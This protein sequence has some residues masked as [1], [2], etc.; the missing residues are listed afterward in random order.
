VKEVFPL[1]ADFEKFPNFMSH[2]TSVTR[3]G[4]DRTH[5]VLKGPAG[6]PLEWDAQTTEITFGR[7]IAWRTVNSH[8]EHT[9]EV[10]F[11]DIGDETEL[12]VTM[13]Y[14]TPLG[15]LGDWAGQ[16][17]LDPQGRL[18]HDLENF[19]RFCEKSA[20]LRRTG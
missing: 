6:L 15:A 19:K 14:D 1:W 4:D 3:T 20:P 10:L 7:R 5:W 9:G 16:T 17:F 2:V 12:T 11:H 13:T 18:E 8:V